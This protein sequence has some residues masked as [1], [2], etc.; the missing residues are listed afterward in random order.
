MYKNLLTEAIK[1]ISLAREMYAAKY[2]EDYDVDWAVV[3]GRS[4]HFRKEQHE[5][6]HR[7]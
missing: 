4:P 3:V 1:K 6:I 7:A 5:R 2:S